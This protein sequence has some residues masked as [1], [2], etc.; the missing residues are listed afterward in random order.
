[1]TKQPD[2]LKTLS[3]QHLQKAEFLDLGVSA[4]AMNA[5]FMVVRGNSY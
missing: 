1:M 2:T 4:L 5:G 3:R